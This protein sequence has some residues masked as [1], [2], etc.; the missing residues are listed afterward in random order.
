MNAQIP[1]LIDTIDSLVLVRDRIA[2]ILLVESL[3]QQQKAIA[4]DRD[5]L[6]WT[7]RIYTERAEP[8]DTYIDVPDP[9][10]VDATPLVNVAWRE[11]TFD[12]KQ[13]NVVETQRGDGI[14]LI[15]CYGYGVSREDPQGGHIPGDESARRESHRTAGLVR[16][17]LMASMYT[18]LGF[19]GRVG[20]RWIDSEESLP[21][22]ITDDRAIQH[23][24]CTRL[25]LRV[26]YN[27]YSPQAQPTTLEAVSVNVIRGETGQLL[28]RAQF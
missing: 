3:S 8:W 18:S 25:T 14:F 24:A 12:R 11:T 6:P 28:L 4:A 19:P 17:I 7:I 15:D 9:D 1:G 23:I 2:E 22:A 20:T 21:T 5:P 13:G 26:Q 27:E 16:Q 10:S